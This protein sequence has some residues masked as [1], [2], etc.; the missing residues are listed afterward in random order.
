MPVREEQLNG[1]ISSVINRFAGSMGWTAIEET[2]RAQRGGGRPDIVIARDGAPPIAI[3]NEYDPA[4]TV[5]GD[6]QNGL[7]LSLILE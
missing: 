6:C 2:D 1:R 3:E 4:R 5:E 7:A